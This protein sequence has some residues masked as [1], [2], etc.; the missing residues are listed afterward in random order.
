MPIT[1]FLAGLDFDAEATRAMGLAF[2]KACAAL[3]LADRS[4]PLTT[5]VAD[6]IIAA[7]RAGE[8][9]PERLCA[10]TLREL[11]SGGPP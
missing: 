9:D 3:G 2:K 1:P 6:K 8:R 4:D 5:M 10:A 11:R 7:A